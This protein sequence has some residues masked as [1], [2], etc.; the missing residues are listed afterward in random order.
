MSIQIGR[1]LKALRK[2]K[3]V[4]QDQLAK[5]AGIENRQTIG[6]IENGER[7]LL[8]RELRAMMEFMEFPLEKFTNPYIP[9]GE[10]KFSWRQSEVD[11]VELDGFENTAKE[12][13]GAYQEIGQ[14][15]GSNAL[16]RDD[17][18]DLDS[19][20]SFED[21]CAAGDRLAQEYDLGSVPADRLIDMMQDELGILVLMV[22][23][24][25]GISGAACTLPGLKTVLVNRNEH[26]V[27]RN[28]DLAHELFHLLTWKTLPPHRLDGAYDNAN[29]SAQAVKKLKR[30]E[31]LADN[32]AGALLAPTHVLRGCDI[33]TEP[34]ALASWT[35]KKAG[36]LKIS[37]EALKWRL[38]QFGIPA[39]GL[40]P[41]AARRAAANRLTAPKDRPALFSRKYIERMGEGINAGRISTRRVAGL[42]GISLD[43]MGELFDHYGVER[44]SL[45]S[46]ELLEPS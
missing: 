1:R 34:A 42:L 31:T 20:S 18:L 11:P 41:V 24:V 17:R 5:A 30:T 15:L 19:R 23:A 12:W 36:E 4:S 10:E 37:F 43:D 2:L 26:E 21:A 7:R 44:P 46:N 9:L 27:R 28:F 14:E 25:D 29:L 35:V 16:I 45:L 32:F 40:D 22:D 3:N 38:C 13:M 8:G 33:P 39:Q 6:Q